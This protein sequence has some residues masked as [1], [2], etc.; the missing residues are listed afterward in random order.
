M[1]LSIQLC[2]V[3]Y[4]HWFQNHAWSSSLYLMSHF[5]SKVMHKS[6]KCMGE[7]CNGM[8]FLNLLIQQKVNVIQL[9]HVHKTV[10]T[11]CWNM[12]IHIWKVVL[13]STDFDYMKQSLTGALL[14]Q[15]KH[16]LQLLQLLQLL[17]MLQVVKIPMISSHLATGSRIIY[18]QTIV[19][20]L[21]M[22][23]LYVPVNK[24]YKISIHLQ[25]AKFWLNIEVCFNHR[26]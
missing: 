19:F 5:R 14:V 21:F 22:G 16:L 18:S 25:F 13:F 3:L 7:M 15:L 12:V 23:V 6:E 4:I 1:L 20:H 9:C 24:H 2:S 17:H 11:N 26:M 10:W 8:M